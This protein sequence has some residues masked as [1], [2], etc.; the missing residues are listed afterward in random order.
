MTEWWSKGITEKYT[1][2]FK[3]PV[4]LK[5]NLCKTSEKILDLRKLSDYIFCANLYKEY[6]PDLIKMLG[7]KE[8][9]T[10]TKFICIFFDIIRIKYGYEVII[11]NFYKPEQG[12]LEKVSSEIN[13][14][15]G[16]NYIETQVCLSEECANM[17][18][19]AYIEIEE[20]YHEDSKKI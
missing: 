12:Y 17:C 20:V 9:I 10:N 2:K 18:K 19:K 11:G 7:S 3:D 14:Y 16:L 5:T 6:L 8:P 15:N 4:I 13:K 1:P